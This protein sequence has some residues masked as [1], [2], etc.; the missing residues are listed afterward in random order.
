MKISDLRPGDIVCSTDQRGTCYYRID[1]V[2]KVRVDVTHENGRTMRL[3]PVLFDRK[4]TY[5]VPAFH[6]HPQGKLA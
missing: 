2:H 4:V 1:A 6:P 5:P 3:H